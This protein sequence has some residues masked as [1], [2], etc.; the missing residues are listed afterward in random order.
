MGQYSNYLNILLISE[1]ILKK[2]TILNDN[3][4]GKYILPA[5]KMSQDIDL[6]ELVGTPLVNSLKYLINENLIPSQDVLE[7]VFSFAT[8][9]L[10]DFI[11]PYLSWQTLKNIQ[12]NI[13]YKLT[14]SG[15]IENNDL[16]KAKISFNDGKSLITQYE[17]YATAYAL[18]LKQ[19]ICD[20][21]SKVA[22]IIN[23]VKSAIGT[24][25]PLQLDKCTYGKE[26][27]LFGIYFGRR[28]KYGL[29]K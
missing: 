2:N 16:N 8:T 9:L 4:D 21:S 7:P 27:P 14:N 24:N 19:F 17:R 20:N 6:E 15:V 1:D 22:E 25:N 12:I 18:K 29:Y 5:I 13:N 28:N 26:P 3:V 23:Y 10:D 11:I